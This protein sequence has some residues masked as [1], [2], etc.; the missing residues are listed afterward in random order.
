[1][2]FVPISRSSPVPLSP[3]ALTFVLG[4]LTAFGAL[5]IDMYLPSLP[6]I[7]ISLHASA[8]LVQLTLATFMVGMGLGQLVYGPV[9]DRLGRRRPL[10][11][12]ISLYVVA[13]L[14][15]ALATTIEQ[16]LAARFLQAVGA[17][18]GPVIARAVVRDM[19]AGR[20]IARVLS[21]MM[22][23]VGVAPILAPLVGGEL[24]TLFGWRAIFV[25]LM[26]FGLV[27]LVLAWVAVPASQVGEQSH[28][29]R[30]SFAAV[31]ADRQFVIGALTGAFAGS[32]L[33]AYISSS[34][35]VFMRVH[36]FSPQ[37]FALL[38]GVNAATFIGASQLNRALLARHSMQALA[39]SASIGLCVAATAMTAVAYLSSAST[40]ALILALL[41]S[42]A[43]IGMVLPNATALA[44]VEHA[45][46][47]G[48]AS[49]LLGATH[50][51][52]A[53]LTVSLVGSLHDGSA[54]PMAGAM[55]SCACLVLALSLR[56]RRE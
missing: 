25:A 19:F 40:G 14:G 10:L 12:G 42:L 31:L 5:S 45:P 36:G 15:C 21:L 56:L 16:L 53:A 35:F 13:S 3:R 37:Q 44:L 26:L 1:M 33:F 2:S 23:V 46:R 22:L 4:V 48:V 24:L 11:L 9:S 28:T 8:S 43:A 39:R 49:S 29:L 47:A 30:E 51:A 34:P 55:L 17:A 32:A 50:F 38:F 52:V 7:A 27:A 6:A 18:A 41:A 54:L 20:E